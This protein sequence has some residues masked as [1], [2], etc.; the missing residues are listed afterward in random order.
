M[1]EYKKRIETLTG[2]TTPGLNEPWSND[3]KGVRPHS[4]KRQHQMLFDVLP[5]TYIFMWGTTELSSDK[6]VWYADEL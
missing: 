1:K 6:P 2:N 3:N 4:L 5:R